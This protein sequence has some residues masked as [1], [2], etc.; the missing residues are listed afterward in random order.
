MDRT[1]WL[2]RYRR[3]WQERDAA[4]AGELFTEDAIYR[5]QAFEQ[6]H[7]GR[8]GIRRYWEGVTAGQQD[9]ELAYGTPIA[10]DDRLA[11]EW[12]V[13]LRHEGAEVSIAGEF[14]L[15]FA[16]SGQCRELREYWVLTKGR[17]DPPEGWG[18]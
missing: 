8:D 11:V 17:H 14:M 6:A 2:E 7:A 12:W 5:D 3:A 9:I 4:A 13:N 16:A 15:R 10:V 18:R 1:E